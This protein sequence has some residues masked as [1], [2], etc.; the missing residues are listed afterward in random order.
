MAAKRILLTGASGN[1]GYAVLGEL[2]RRGYDV[3]VLARRQLPGTAGYRPLFGDLSR[4]HEIAGEIA[5]CDGIIHCAS[6][7]S[8]DRRT[9]MREDIEGTANL[10]DAWRCGPFVF[11]SS[12]TV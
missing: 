8:N 10:L 4:I 7:R 1:V 5:G 2:L 9:V 11:T 12:Q 3:V 6:P